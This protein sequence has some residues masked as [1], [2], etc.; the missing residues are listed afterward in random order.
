[1]PL[2]G[3]AGPEGAKMRI[4]PRSPGDTTPLTPAIAEALRKAGIDPDKFTVAPGDPIG[5]A[6]GGFPPAGSSLEHRFAFTDR[7]DALRCVEAYADGGR[8]VTITRDEQGWMVSIN[9]AVDPGVDDAEA[10]RRVAAEVAAFGGAD[11]GLAR[12]S[13]TTRIRLK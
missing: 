5:V 4:V 10:H 8:P 12:E 1:M 9:S 2:F 3:K 7:A 13:V 11:R 6:M